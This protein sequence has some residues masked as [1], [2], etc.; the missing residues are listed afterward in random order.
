M[1]LFNVGLATT[2]FFD[3]AASSKVSLAMLLLWVISYG[4]SA[5]P[6]GFVA[7]GEVSTPRLR[8]VSTGFNL[9]LYGIGLYVMKDTLTTKKS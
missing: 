8:A 1:L 4:L 5:G 6:L 9:F 3:T 2:G 7:S